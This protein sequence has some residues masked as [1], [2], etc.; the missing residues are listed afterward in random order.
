M[1]HNNP[2]V[3]EEYLCVTCSMFQQFSERNLLWNCTNICIEKFLD[4]LFISLVAM[5]KSY[6]QTFFLCGC[7][8]G[9]PPFQFSMFKKM[10][11]RYSVDFRIFLMQI[12]TNLI[13]NYLHQEN[14]KFH[15]ISWWHFLE[16]WKLM[17]S[18]KSISLTVPCR[19]D[20][21][22]HT[23]PKLEVLCFRRS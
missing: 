3:S 20:R 5:I 22:M 11:S 23:M 16:H 4:L 9:F 1:M 18:S 19:Y 6:M 10:P 15:K 7:I 13:S 8:Y 2:I 12:I 17:L 21:L 14:S